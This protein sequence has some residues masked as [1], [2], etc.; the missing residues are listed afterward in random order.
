MSHLPQGLKQYNT[1]EKKQQEEN[2]KKP[3]EIVEDCPA[4]FPCDKE[5]QHIF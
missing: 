4:G 3:N 2:K 5:V 1:K